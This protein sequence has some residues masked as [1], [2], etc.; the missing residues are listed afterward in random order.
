MKAILRFPAG[1]YSDLPP[2]LVADG[3]LIKDAADKY[4]DEFAAND[5]SKDPATFVVIDDLSDVFETSKGR[6]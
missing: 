1:Q 2:S 6:K 3:I 4:R 5:K